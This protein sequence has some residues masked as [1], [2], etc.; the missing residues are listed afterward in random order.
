MKEHIPLDRVPYHC[1]LCGF[2]CQDRATLDQHVTRYARHVAEE[3][4]LGP[5]NYAAVLRKSENPIFVTELCLIPCGNDSDT[6]DPFE[7]QGATVPEA[8]GLLSWPFVGNQHPGQFSGETT[9]PTFPAHQ[10]HQLPRPVLASPPNV[11]AQS[12]FQPLQTIPT[13]SG[14]RSSASTPLLDETLFGGLTAEFERFLEEPFRGTKRATPSDECTGM[15]S[16]K[17]SKMTDSSIQNELTEELCSSLDNGFRK[18]RQ[19][20]DEDTKVLMGTQRLMKTLLE[21][22]SAIKRVVP[23]DKD[24]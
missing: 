11:L 6:E 22:L 16:P 5:V 14:H 18:L 2:R 23:I 8:R 10:G 12:V 21:E 19:A 17:V 3:R 1:T 24:D 9:Y 4:K 13:S 15:P 7:D 20:V